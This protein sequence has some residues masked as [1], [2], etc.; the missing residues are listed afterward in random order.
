MA[1]VLS[2][3]QSPAKSN[4]SSIMIKSVVS[5]FFGSNCFKKPPTFWLWCGAGCSCRGGEQEGSG[6]VLGGCFICGF[7]SSSIRLRR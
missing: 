7:G 5:K 1:V 3:S 4:R 6:S 2:S